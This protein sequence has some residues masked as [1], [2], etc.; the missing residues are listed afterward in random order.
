MLVEFD[1]VLMEV[2]FFH[3]SDTP[4]SESYFSSSGNV[5]LNEFFILYD[6]DGFLSCGNRFLF[7]NLFFY[8][9]KL[10][11]KLMAHFLLEIIYFRN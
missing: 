2:T 11:L 10:S 9:G 1:F 6:E 7:F 4:A 3:F 8:N 5:F